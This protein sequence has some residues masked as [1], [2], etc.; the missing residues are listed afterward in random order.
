MPLT[1]RVIDRVHREY[2]EHLHHWRWLL[3]SL[4]GGERYRRAVYGTGAITRRN[5]VRHKHERPGPRRNLSTAG[6][7]LAY[8]EG[9]A[10]GAPLS[11][12][13][14]VGPF[15]EDRDYL[16]R[17]ERTPVPSFVQEAVS[18][19]LSEIYTKE[20]K[21]ESA[22][23][24][25]T[26]W[27]L[28]VDGTG[29]TIDEWMADTVA[30]TLLVLGQ[31]DLYVDRPPAPDG[32]EVVTRAD[33]RRFGLDRAVASVI[34][35][36]NMPWWR[37]DPTT[38]RYLE[39]V[40]IERSEEVDSRG[41][42]L[43]Y[44]RHWTATESTLYTE[45]GDVMAITPHPYGRVPIER[46]FDRRKLRCR[47]VGQ[48]SYGGIGERQ[49]EVYNLESE[50]ILS[51]TTQ[52]HPITQGPEDYIEAGGEIPAGPGNVLPK[53]KNVS[54]TTVHYEKWEVLD[55]P[56]G[57]AESIRED[58][59]RHRDAVDRAAKMTKPAGTQ[60]TTG[61]VVA[62]SGISKAL[63]QKSGNAYLSEK[64]KKLAK[65]ER[66]AAELVLTVL[67]SGD[68]AKVDAALGSMTLAYPTSFNLL[69]A[70]EV[71]TIATE[72]QAVLAAA[73]DAPATET[74]FLQAL[75]REGLPGRDDDEYEQ[76]DEEIAS[77]VDAKSTMKDR[78]R[79]SLPVPPGADAGLP[80]DGN[81]PATDGQLVPASDGYQSGE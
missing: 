18:A 45:R 63:D 37:T 11:D 3:D 30:P 24:G 40:V 53:K 62:Q 15:V 7:G 80:P 57:P 50:L 32:T 78:M 39:C 46:V 33:V 25:L 41:E 66:A 20:I 19:H 60:G 61:N 64:A 52:A 72:F 59:Q 70:E 8:D 34:L 9:Y 79:E 42:P 2:A 76:L 65:C 14:G 17:L 44:Y 23:P 55:F 5:L 49:R 48:S 12:G 1:D 68:A 16:L 6:E 43:C 21:R 73:G 51:N 54:G 77:A 81:P 22:D 71:A 75:V 56:K 74:L 26:A 35:P 38:G 27:W 69:S 31:I 36:E 47:N 10:Y 67:H 28:D 13:T 4:E 29:T 58:V